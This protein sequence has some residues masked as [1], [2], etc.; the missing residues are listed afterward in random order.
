V[1]D[2]LE[3][4]ERR[5]WEALSGPDG[6]AF[7]REV[8]ADEGVMVFPGLVMDKEGALKVMGEVAPWA[9]FELHDLRAIQPLP[10]CGMVVYHADAQRTGERTYQAEMTSVYVRRDDRWQLVLHQQSPRR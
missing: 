5:G 2:E 6:A 4:L 9:T 1:T 3:R 8:M 10:D 7:Y